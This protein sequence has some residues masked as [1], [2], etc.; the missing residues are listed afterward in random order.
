MCCIKYVGFIVEETTVNQLLMD[1]KC[2]AVVILSVTFSSVLLLYF[3]LT[4]AHILAM[5]ISFLSLKTDLLRHNLHTLS[6]LFKV[7]NLMMFS[8][9]IELSSHLHDTL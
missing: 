4:Y 3:P 2:V 8:K 9:Y 1:L 5:K 7:N 6:Y